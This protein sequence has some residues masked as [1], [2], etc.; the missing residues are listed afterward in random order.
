MARTFS[1]HRRQILPALAA[2]LLLA[3]LVAGCSGQ[4]A[5]PN[6]VQQAQNQTITLYFV[7]N[8]PTDFW[9][10]PELRQIPQQPDMPKA[11]L[12]ELIKGPTDP[13]LNG[14]IPKETKV[15]DVTVKNFTAY[16]NFSSEITRMSV[17]SSGEALVIA[18][19]ANTLIKF[20][21]VEQVVILVEGQQLETL[22][23]HV[24]LTEP[25][26]RNEHLLKLE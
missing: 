15:L 23:G 26:G 11:A 24:D 3:L 8:T 10:V 9:L 5:K 20:P 16:P 22:A 21:G 12:E 14:L 19:I 25:I 18:S 17:G 2:L 13:E 4:E 7:Q 1:N 6:D